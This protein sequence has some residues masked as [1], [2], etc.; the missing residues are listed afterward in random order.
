M[1]NET[2]S[3]QIEKI[4]RAIQEI[5]NVLHPFMKK[6]MSD[7]GAKF[8]SH[9][10]KSRLS[11]SGV[12]RRSGSLAR[13]FNRNVFDQDGKLTLVVWTTSKYA[14]LQEFGTAGLPG[15]VL[16]PKKA[17]ALAI[18]VGPALT[19]AGVS[20]FESPRQVAGLQVFKPRFKLPFLGMVGRGKNAMRVT[21]W[22]LLRKSVKIVGNMKLFVTW[23][24]DVP[25]AVDMMA[26]AADEA[27][28]KNYK[29]I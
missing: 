4:N 17:K 16:R 20:K 8:L 11:G 2:M 28:A 21:P 27:F 19:G 14:R 7:F 26:K 15:G 25:Q 24:E 3:V 12:R 5:P 22:F 6:A 18:P 29:R 10:T 9:F 23:K 1:P 13:S